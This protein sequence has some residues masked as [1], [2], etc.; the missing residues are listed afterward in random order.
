MSI[1][2]PSKTPSI[3]EQAPQSEPDQPEFDNNEKP[4][5]AYDENLSGWENIQKAREINDM[6]E[7]FATPAELPSLPRLPEDLAAPVD[8]TPVAQDLIG[9]RLN[10][11]STVAEQMPDG[12]YKIEKDTS[13]DNTPITSYE[14]VSAEEVNKRVARDN[15]IEQDTS[16]A[17]AAKAHAV[18]DIIRRALEAPE[19]ESIPV[20]SLDSEPTPITVK[21][22]KLRHAIE[23]ALSDESNGYA[24]KK[25][26]A[27]SERRNAQQD[28][29]TA[30]EEV[31]SELE[32]EDEPT[33]EDGNET[34]V[35]VAEKKPSLFERIKNAIS[36]GENGSKRKSTRRDE[37]ALLRAQAK[38]ERIQAKID[39]KNEEAAK[40]AA[41]RE[42]M[43]KA[44]KEKIVEDGE[45]AAKD[46]LDSAI[47][48]SEAIRAD[49]IAQ[50]EAYDGEK[51][52]RA[53]IARVAQIA[54][55]LTTNQ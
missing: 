38:A 54:S 10:D 41:E 4:G 48:A 33:A 8:A 22:G 32:V 42:A 25:Y 2:A 40:Q 15:E 52:R 9:T 51:K 21:K 30:P 31:I 43:I 23:F 44:T 39:T 16:E 24:V 7:Q 35:A 20:T 34:E 18:A 29:D 19:S 28:E 55:R 3:N 26:K 14:M 13:T 49:A 53:I 1:E 50:A 37:K 5:L 47:E 46:Y 36:R 6:N 27:Y 17:D 11:G 12:T 45:Q